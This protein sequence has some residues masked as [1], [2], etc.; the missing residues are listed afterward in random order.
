MK[1]LTFTHHLFIFFLI[2]SILIGLI[3]CSGCNGNG[4]DKTITVEQGSGNDSNRID[5]KMTD[6]KSQTIIH[7]APKEKCEVPLTTQEVIEFRNSVIGKLGLISSRPLS[8]SRREINSLKPLIAK[9]EGNIC[10]PEQMH[11]ETSMLF[12][13]YGSVIMLGT[14]DDF[15]VHP[16]D[17]FR[18]GFPYI[19]KSK[20]LNQ[21]VWQ[22]DVDMKAYVE[23]EDAYNNLGKYNFAEK[24]NLK[25][26]TCNAL[27]VLMLGA[28]K[29]RIDNQCRKLAD[30]IDNAITDNKDIGDL[31][32]FMKAP[33]GDTDY[34]LMM[35][36]V[37][38]I[39]VG[40]G[41]EFTGPEAIP[42]SNGY[43]LIKYTTSGLPENPTFEWLVNSKQKIIKAH[44]NAAAVTEQ[45]IRNKKKPKGK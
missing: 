19:Q 22:S 28:E 36:A 37:K 17:P 39:V 12:R 3:G 7:E 6:I 5:I 2:S 38:M 4:G 25:K 26:Y 27:T 9:A 16:A 34:Q 13:L 21:E 8:M 31:V 23:L 32:Y 44:N 40:S 35:E 29:E 18:E 15:S 30:M 43:T 33:I 10:Y 45:G 14:N 11:L 20:E 41:G 24:E 1:N 42:Q